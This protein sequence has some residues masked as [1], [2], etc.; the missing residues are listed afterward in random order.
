VRQAVSSGVQTSDMAESKCRCARSRMP[1]ELTP[2]VVGVESTGEVAHLAVLVADDQ[3]MTE[4]IG[5]NGHAWAAIEVSL[6]A[7]R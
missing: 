6:G 2:S 7:R 1:M 4:R 5:E 3:L